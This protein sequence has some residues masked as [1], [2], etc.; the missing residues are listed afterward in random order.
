MERSDADFFSAHSSGFSAKC[1]RFSA[2]MVNQDKFMIKENIFPSLFICYN[3]KKAERI[4]DS[5]NL[6]ENNN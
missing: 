6:A 1:K 5:E 3:I 4:G 2:K